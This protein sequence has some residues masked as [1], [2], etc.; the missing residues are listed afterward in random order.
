M[1]LSAVNHHLMRGFSIASA[2]L[3]RDRA[4]SNSAPLR[5]TSQGWEALHGV[6]VPAPNR[7]DLEDQEW[8]RYVKIFGSFHVNIKLY[9]TI[10]ESL[11]KSICLININQYQMGSISRHT[12]WRDLKH[13]SFSKDRHNKK[14]AKPVMIISASISHS[15]SQDYLGGI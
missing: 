7:E 14:Q 6:C 13:I 3:G 10:F 9:Q 4:A 11:Y 1:I 2:S 12:P 8:S 5:V 15:K